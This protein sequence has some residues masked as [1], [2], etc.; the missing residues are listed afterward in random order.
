VFNRRVAVKLTLTEFTASPSTLP[1]IDVLTGECAD[2]FE[3]VRA[4]SAASF[5]WYADVG[6]HLGDLLFGKRAHGR[7][8]VGPRRR[9]LRWG[10]AA[11]VLLSLPFLIVG[12]TAMAG[13]V[14]GLTLLLVSAAVYGYTRPSAV[15]SRDGFSVVVRAHPR[16]VEA[17]RGIHRQG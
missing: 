5:P 14:G 11:L 2:A 17:L 8:P 1:M 4:V 10:A 7:L 15:V 6:Y 16:F 9:R 12:M 13:A 3:R